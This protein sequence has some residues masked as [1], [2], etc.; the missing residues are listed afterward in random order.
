MAASVSV[1]CRIN[2]VFVYPFFTGI[3]LGPADRAAQIA[4]LVH[5]DVRLVVWAKQP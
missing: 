5:N 3:S 1:V 2:G 4:L